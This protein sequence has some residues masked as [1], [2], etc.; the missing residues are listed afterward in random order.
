MIN[1]R[2]I[3]LY[4]WNKTLIVLTK[5]PLG[6]SDTNYSMQQSSSAHEIKPYHY[7]T[8]LTRKSLSQLVA[9]DILELIVIFFQRK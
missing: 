7:Y 8:N 2:F 6:L 9:D 4:W 3:G 1:I 5:F